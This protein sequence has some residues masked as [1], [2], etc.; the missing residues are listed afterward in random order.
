[1]GPSGSDQPTSCT[2]GIPLSWLGSLQIPAAPCDQIPAPLG[3]QP[4]L[5]VFCERHDNFR[6]SGE[7]DEGYAQVG[8]GRKGGSERPIDSLGSLLPSEVRQ[9]AGT[10]AQGESQVPLPLHPDT[11]RNTHRLGACT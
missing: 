11:H 2:D 6:I 4:C 5:P 10:W 1:M 3:S 9:P 8:A 7:D